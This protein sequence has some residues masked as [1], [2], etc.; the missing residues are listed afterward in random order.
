MATAQS[1]ALPSDPVNSAFLRV[2]V[3]GRI[4]RSA[5]FVS[6]ATRPSSRNSARLGQSLSP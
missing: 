5:T 1:R 4:E 2:S 6:I 3:F